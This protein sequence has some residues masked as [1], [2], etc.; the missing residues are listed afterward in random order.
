MKT[1]EAIKELSEHPK[2]K[3]ELVG[4]AKL[5]NNIGIIMENHRGYL[6]VVN[7]DLDSISA[8]FFSGEWKAVQ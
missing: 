6:Q 1:W 2:L 3:F 5:L 4:G 8:L 7:R